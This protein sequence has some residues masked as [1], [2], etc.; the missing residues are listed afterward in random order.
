LAASR[1][2]GLRTARLWHAY[3]RP[4]RNQHTIFNLTTIGSRVFFSLFDPAHYGQE[5]WTSDGTAAGTMMVKD[6]NP[7]AGGSSPGAMTNF[8]GTLYFSANDGTQWL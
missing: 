2:S 7:G 8:N 4:A 6:I 5:L 3:R 1:N